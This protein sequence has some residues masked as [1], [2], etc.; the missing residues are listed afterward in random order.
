MDLRA[1]VCFDMR[2]S[3][4]Q[5]FSHS[6]TAAKTLHLAAPFGLPVA[7]TPPTSP[8]ADQTSLPPVNGG[9]PG[10]HRRLLRFGRQRLGLRWTETAENTSRIHRSLRQTAPNVSSTPVQ[11]SSHI[12]NLK[13]EARA[14][15]RPKWGLMD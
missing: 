6:A 8:G 4:Q 1:L 13:H 2:M 3:S 5:P 12:P 7:Q 15:C 14:I 10:A 11:N 9:K